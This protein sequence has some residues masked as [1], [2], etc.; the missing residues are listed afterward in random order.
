LQEFGVKL[1][2][3]APRLPLKACVAWKVVRRDNPCLP[4]LPPGV[5][6]QAQ[7]AGGQQ[8]KRAR[9]GRGGGA[10]DDNAQADRRSWEAMKSLFGEIFK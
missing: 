5:G 6:Q 8:G 2:K 4:L 7:Q 10:A 3:L 1:R 9:L